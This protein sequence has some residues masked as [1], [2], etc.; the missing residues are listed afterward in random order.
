MKYNLIK[1]VT[2]S[3]CFTLEKHNIVNQLYFNLK[4]VKNNYPHY[5]YMIF[6]WKS[7]LNI[8]DKSL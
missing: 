1:Y 3:L 2:E 6:F 8:I 5:Y 7:L 4:N